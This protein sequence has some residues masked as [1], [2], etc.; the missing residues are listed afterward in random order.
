MCNILPSLKFIIKKI[1]I[2]HCKIVDLGLSPDRASLPNLASRIM[3][4]EINIKI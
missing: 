1:K 4:L 3:D 2:T